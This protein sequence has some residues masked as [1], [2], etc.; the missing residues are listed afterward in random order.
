MPSAAAAVLLDSVTE[1]TV[2]HTSAR[3]GEGADTWG[4]DPGVDGP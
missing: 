2:A 3:I 1:V 4:G